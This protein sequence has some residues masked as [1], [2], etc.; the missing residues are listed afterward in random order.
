MS[1]RYRR[2]CPPPHWCLATPP[3]CPTLIPFSRRLLVPFWPSYFILALPCHPV[4]SCVILP[5]R[6]YRRSL[7]SPF[8][9]LILCLFYRQWEVPMLV[10]FELHDF[11]VFIIIIFFLF[12]TTAAA[13][14]NPKSF[15]VLFSRSSRYWVDQDVH[16]CIFSIFI[17]FRHLS[18]FSWSSWYWF[19]EIV[20]CSIWPRCSFVKLIV[21]SSR[22]SV[23]H[24][25]LFLIMQPIVFT[26][27]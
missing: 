7:V 5:H 22:G 12:F 18:F 26:N 17:L 23:L 8:H 2:S 24:K 21:Q 15:W 19:T 14:K 10:A 13:G 20:H 9:F 4:L 16:C 6:Y 11:C 3:S 1:C 25:T 27:R